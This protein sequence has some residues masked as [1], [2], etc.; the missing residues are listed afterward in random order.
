[1]PTTIAVIGLG[2]IGSRCAD[3]LSRAGFHIRTWNR[4][5]KN[6]PDSVDT[7]SDAVKEADC[8]ALYLK[9]GIAVREV[10]HTFKNTLTPNQTVVNHSTIDLD[11]THWLAQKC[12][13]I[14]CAFLDAPFTGSKVAAGQGALVY[15]VGGDSETLECI[16]PVLEAT[17]KE[18]KHLGPIGSATVVKIA[19]NLI[20]ATTVQALSEALAITTAYDIPADVLIESVTSNAC[21]SPLAAMKLPTMASGDFETHFSL[22]NMLKDSGFALQLAQ[23]KDLNVPGIQATAHAMEE[24]CKKG[25]AQLDFSAL[26]KAY[27][28]QSLVCDESV[29]HDDFIISP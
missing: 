1:M 17:S 9:D 10:F 16:R 28:T 21:G 20:S 12:Q 15:Y 7:A 24:G 18:I 6:R 19:T 25:D 8:I 4:T 26:F 23:D 22:E 2:I 11:T 3:N 27:H 29:T 5:P 14:G 13:E